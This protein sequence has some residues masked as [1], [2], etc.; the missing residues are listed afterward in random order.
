M[1][2]WNPSE[3]SGSGGVHRNGVRRV[4]ARGVHVPAVAVGEVADEGIYKRKIAGNVY[5]NLSGTMVE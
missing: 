4:R 5:F 3:S 1:V 2:F